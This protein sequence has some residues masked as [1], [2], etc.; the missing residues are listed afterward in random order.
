MKK[1]DF[2]WKTIELCDWNHE[3]DDDL[4]LLPVINYLA[5][6]EDSDI[7]E[8]DNQMSELLYALDTKELAKQCENVSGYFSDDEFLYSRCVA[9]INGTDYYEAALQ[10]EVKDMWDLE[11]E[12][13]LYVPMIAWALKNQK[14]EDDYPHETSVSYETGSNEEGWK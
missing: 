5:S 6:K 4:V 9:I 12:A 2:F 13:L 1:Y 7:F 8:F 3:G 11:F 14:D 10:G